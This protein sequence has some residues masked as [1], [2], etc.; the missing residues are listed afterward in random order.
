MTTDLGLRRY[1]PGKTDARRDVVLTP[2]F[3]VIVP[4]QSNVQGKI[5]AK[6]PIIL[7]EGRVVV[8]SQMNFICR[9]RQSAGGRNG[10]EAGINRAEGSKVICGGKE[11]HV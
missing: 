5:V 1:L 10:E 9:G 4:A 3:R 7:E 2:K 11:L 8:V 6:P